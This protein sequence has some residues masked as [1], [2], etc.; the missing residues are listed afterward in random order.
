[1]N[2]ITIRGTESV[3]PRP[4]FSNLQRLQSSVD[5]GAPGPIAVAA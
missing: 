1:M 5:V 4:S 2:E 3:P